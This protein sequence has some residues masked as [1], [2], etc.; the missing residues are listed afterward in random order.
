MP[1]PALGRNIRLFISAL[2]EIGLHGPQDGGLVAQEG[3]LEAGLILQKGGAG[4][5]GLFGLPD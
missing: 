4:L 1:L 2:P 5:H 3:G